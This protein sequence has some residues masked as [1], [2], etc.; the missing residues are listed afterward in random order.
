MYKERSVYRELADKIESICD[1]HTKDKGKMFAELV[2]SINVENW[3]QKQF[4]TIV[5]EFERQIYG[6]DG[7]TLEEITFQ[8]HDET[9]EG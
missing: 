5:K 9:R 3:N 6:V 1:Q 7:H 4:I 8:I 2:C